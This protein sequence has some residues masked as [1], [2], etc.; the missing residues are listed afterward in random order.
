MRTPDGQECPYYYRDTQRWHA[1]QEECRLL[2]PTADAERWH[3]ALCATCP[4]PEIRRANACPKMTLRGRIR[5]RLL[6]FWE[7]PRVLV[8]A[9]CAEGPIEDPRVG[10]G[11]CHV[12]LTFVVA[13]PPEEAEL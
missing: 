9:H 1:D 7:G 4:V 3:S 12:Q 6:R 10:C 8:T 13:A 5:R 2:A 11:H